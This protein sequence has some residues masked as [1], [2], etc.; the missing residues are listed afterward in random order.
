MSVKGVI[1]D[2]LTEKGGVNQLDKISFILF[3]RL[4][5]EHRLCLLL[6]VLLQI[7]QINKYAIT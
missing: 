7:I 6:Y 3:N 5:N 2:S 1:Q 4:L